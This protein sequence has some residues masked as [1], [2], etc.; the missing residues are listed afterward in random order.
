MITI[1]TI[2]GRYIILKLH[3]YYNS[4]PIMINKSGNRSS[5]GLVKY[6]H[7]RPAD[8]QAML[9]LKHLQAKFVCLVNE[10]GAMKPFLQLTESHD[11]DLITYN[12]GFL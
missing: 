5:F 2:F 11:V 7:A 10:K 12:Q 1:N 3:C 6:S 4:V 8:D 9:I